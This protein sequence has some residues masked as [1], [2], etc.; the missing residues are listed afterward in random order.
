M[1]RTQLSL[2]PN[3]LLQLAEDLEMLQTGGI[4]VEHAAG[5]TS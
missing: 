4:K 5:A 1:R 2:A 3:D